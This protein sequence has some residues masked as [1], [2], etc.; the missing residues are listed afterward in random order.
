M[1]E[2][3]KFSAYHGTTKQNAESIKANGFRTPGKIG[4]L[5]FGT[6]FYDRN[7]E[8][9]KTFANGNFPNFP[10][11]VLKCDIVIKQ[12]YVF[13]ITDPCSKDCKEFHSCRQ[14]IEEAIGSV[15]LLVKDISKPFFDARILERICTDKGYKMVRAW[16]YTNNEIE[17]EA[18]LHLSISKFANGVELCLKDLN[19]IKQKILL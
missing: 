17:R 15:N 9:A 13:D 16:T 10:T 14:D 5:G 4:W 6:Y 8:L 12:D 11:A 7:P 1:G 18:H 3:L 2:I 19:F